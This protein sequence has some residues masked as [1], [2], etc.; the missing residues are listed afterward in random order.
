MMRRTI[1]W[2]LLTILVGAA[3]STALW[4]ASVRPVLECPVMY[5]DRP[6][7]ICCQG[8]VNATVEFPA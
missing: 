8:N 7:D 1:L 3:A 4:A 2:G 5:V 6:V